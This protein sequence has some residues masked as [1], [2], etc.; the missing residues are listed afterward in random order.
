MPDELDGARAS[1]WA[2]VI[3]GKSGSLQWIAGKRNAAY[4]DQKNVTITHK[5][6]ARGMSDDELL[7]H[8]ARL[9]L[10]GPLIEGFGQQVD[11]SIAG[12]AKNSEKDKVDPQ[13]SE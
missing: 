12:Q 7:A 3:K 1:A 5:A 2:Q 13:I 11:V 4:A 10:S 9:G 8:A 6:D